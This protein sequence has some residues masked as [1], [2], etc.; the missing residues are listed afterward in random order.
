MKQSMKL[1]VTA[2]VLVFASSSGVFAHPLSAGQHSD[3]GAA[4]SRGTIARNPGLGVGRLATL[5]SGQKNYYAVVR[6]TCSGGTDRA[7]SWVSNVIRIQTA[8]EYWEL[9][10]LVRGQAFEALGDDPCDGGELSHGVVLV[11]HEYPSAV[12]TRRDWTNPTLYKA[13]TFD[14]TWEEI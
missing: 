9:K 5:I 8:R 13:R 6:F 2:M 10:E 1:S 11:H 7:F 3:T 14:V 12:E 4:T